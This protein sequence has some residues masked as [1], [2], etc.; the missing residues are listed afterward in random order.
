MLT[1]ARDNY[2]IPPT[3]TRARD[4]KRADYHADMQTTM[5]TLKCVSLAAQQLSR[6]FSSYNQQEFKEL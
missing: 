2:H 3:L 5:K 6:C 4:N 1:R